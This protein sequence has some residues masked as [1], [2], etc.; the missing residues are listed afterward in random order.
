VAEQILYEMGDP[1]DYITPDVVADF[2]KISL[3]DLGSDRV[4]VQGVTGGPRTD[5]LKVSIAYAS[6][7]KAT[8]TLTYA[9]PDAAAK[10]RAA[11]RILRERLDRLGLAFDEIRTEL[12]GW[13]S[14]HGALAGEPPADLPEVQLRVGVRAAD[15]AAVERFTREIAPLVLTGPPSVTGFAGGR[16]RVQEIMAYWPALIRREEVESGLRVEVRDV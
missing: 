6:G 16:P 3:A 1:T 8:G 9:W 15:R 14:T 7:W 5:F 12:V 13:D 2:T 11:D 10:A 4:R